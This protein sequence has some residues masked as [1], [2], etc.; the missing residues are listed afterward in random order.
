MCQSSLSP[1]P[2]SFLSVFYSARTNL[3]CAGTGLLASSA[4]RAGAAT[5]LRGRNRGTGTPSTAAGSCPGALSSHLL[6]YVRL[7][8]SMKSFDGAGLA[9]GRLK[10]ASDCPKSASGGLKLT[11]GCVESASGG[12]KSASGGL[13]SASGGLKSAS[14]GL[15]SAFGG[16]ELASGGAE[17]ASDGH[18]SMAGRSESAGGRFQLMC[19]PDWWLTLS[20]PRAVATGSCESQ[21]GQLIPSLTLRVLT[22]LM[23]RLVADGVGTASGSD[24]IM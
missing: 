21:R 15:K 13:K 2:L 16:A 4:A 24:R 20:V 7:A 19:V 10:L 17:L 12:L 14:G 18:K 9:S 8:G 6:V 11:S 1:V 22:Q 23:S 3:R 5:R